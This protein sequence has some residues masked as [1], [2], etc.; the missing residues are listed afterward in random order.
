[1]AC[2]G[3]PSSL[4]GVGRLEPFLLALDSAFLGL[5]LLPRGMSYAG[6]VLSALDFV[7]PGLLLFPRGLSKSEFAPLVLDFVHCGLLLLLQGAS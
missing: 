5:L 6:L 4:Q 7:H 3:P 2:F 1:M